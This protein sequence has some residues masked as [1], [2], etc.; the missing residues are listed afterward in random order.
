M[1][2]LFQTFSEEEYD[3]SSTPPSVRIVNLKP[4]GSSIRVTDNNKL[5]YLD[6]LAQYKLATS[7]K[8]QTEQVPIKL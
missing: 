6:L 3:R 4:N 2:N 1:T 5:E 8:E 7:I